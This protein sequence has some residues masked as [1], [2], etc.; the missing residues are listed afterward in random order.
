MSGVH[1]PLD[2][3]QTPRDVEV[4]TDKFALL[5]SPETQKLLAPAS[6]LMRLTLKPSLEFPGSV[7]PGPASKPGSR[8][9]LKGL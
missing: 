5:R 2:M 4:D 7:T 9:L 3:E 1:F 8:F 6:C